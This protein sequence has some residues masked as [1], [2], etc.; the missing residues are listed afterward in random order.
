MHLAYLLDGPSALRQS[1]PSLRFPAPQVQGGCFLGASFPAPWAPWE[2]CLRI[3]PQIPGMKYQPQTARHVG[4]K[5]SFFPFWDSLMAQMIV[6]A[7]SV[8]DPGLIPGLGRS[9]GKVLATHSSILAWRIPWME[10]PGGGSFFLFYIC[11][12]PDVHPKLQG[13]FSLPAFPLW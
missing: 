13:Y 8:E 9:P 10:E 4:N 2:S 6:S 7:C 1:G 11:Q 5:V 3:Q 12:C